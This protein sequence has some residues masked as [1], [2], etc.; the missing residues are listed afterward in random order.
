MNSTDKSFIAQKIR[1]QY[2]EKEHTELDALRALDK[3]VKRPANLFAYIF[4]TL[5]ALV[6]GSGMSLI[7]TELP[8]MLGIENGMLPGVIVG[9]VGLIMSLINYPIYKKL[10][11]SR[12]ARYADEIIAMSDEIINA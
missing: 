1:T 5:G 3:K 7:M 8:S 2:T 12:R 11:A 9:S 10:L 6:T 4:G